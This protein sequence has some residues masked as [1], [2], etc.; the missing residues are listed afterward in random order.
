MDPV[1][2]RSIAGDLQA[3]AERSGNFH[4][5]EPD[6]QE[7]LHPAALKAYPKAAAAVETV[8]ADAVIQKALKVNRQLP[9]FR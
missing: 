9:A 4:M 2:A 5:P 3:S 6:A 1:F 7:L 8:L